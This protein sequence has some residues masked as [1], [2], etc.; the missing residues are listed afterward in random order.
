MEYVS[1][2][3]CPFNYGSVP[4]QLGA[5]GDPLD[6]LV[7][8]PALPLGAEREVSVHGVVR[9]LDAGLVDDKLI[10]GAPPTASDLRGIALFFRFYARVRA[11]MNRVRGL[12]GETRYV[13]VERW[14]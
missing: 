7:L 9:F 10:A 1:P 14:E 6:V 4:G 2:V 3:P 11:G 8:G 5:D 13:G 12:H